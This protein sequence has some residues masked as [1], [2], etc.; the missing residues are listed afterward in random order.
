[1]LTLKLAGLTPETF[2]WL[3]GTMTRSLL[4]TIDGVINL[5]LGVLLVLFPST[6]ATVLGIPRP[7]S[8]FYP[9]ILGAVLLGIGIALCM[10]RGTHALTRG[11]GLHGAIVINL[12]AAFVLAAWLLL[13]DLGLSL[14]G[15]VTLWSVVGILVTVSFAELACVRGGQTPISTPRRPSA[16]SA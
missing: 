9:N 15:L 8:T 14:R 5:C 7:A 10:E 13:G 3:S 6:I 12:C 4:L 1:M 16:D 2:V 11:L